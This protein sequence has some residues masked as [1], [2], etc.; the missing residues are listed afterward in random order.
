MQSAVSTPGTAPARRRLRN[1]QWTVLIAAK[2]LPHAKSRLLDSGEG[3]DPDA[4]ARLVLAI[5]D[6]TIAAAAAAANVSRVVLVADAPGLGGEHVVVQQAPGLNPALREGAAHAARQWPGDGVAA[7]VGDL[8]ALRPEELAE[9]LDLAARHTHAYVADAEGTGTTL[10]TAAPG[11][12]LQPQFGAGSA[13]RHAASA[14]ALDA[15]PGLR[16][17]VDTA[18]DLQAAARVGLGPRT[19]L[20]VSGE[21]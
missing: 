21:Q 16:H 10:L 3:L 6:D 2:S 12:A 13:A 5:R 15:G 20:M 17:D 8:P 9:A 19:S 18:A 1:V 4:H 7:L 11:S 14:V